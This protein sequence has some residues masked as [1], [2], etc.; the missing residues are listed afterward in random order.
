MKTFG[1][2]IPAGHDILLSKR[3]NPP[4]KVLRKYQREDTRKGG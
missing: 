1:G 2:N 3:S 4:P